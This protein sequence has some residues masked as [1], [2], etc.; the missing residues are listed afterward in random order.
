MMQ[1]TPEVFVGPLNRSDRWKF[2]SEAHRFYSFVILLCNTLH[3]GSTAGFHGFFS[4]M[5]LYHLPHF[6]IHL[7]IQSKYLNTPAY[8]I[9]NYQ[10]I[11]RLAIILALWKFA[12]LLLFVYHGMITFSLVMDIYGEFHIVNF[13]NDLV[14][15]SFSYSLQMTS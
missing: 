14:Y 10:H 4:F 11:T 3:L 15:L 12:F 6:A 7:W 2:T 13:L 9:Q 5:V 1:L 8:F